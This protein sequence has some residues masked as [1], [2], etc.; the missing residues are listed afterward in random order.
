MMNPTR[1]RWGASTH[2]VDG[3]P[4][5]APLDYEVGFRDEDGVFRP[6]MIVVGELQTDGLYAAPIADFALAEGDYV[7]A[8]RAIRRDR[9]ELVS[10]WSDSVPFSVAMVPARPTG[11]A[12]E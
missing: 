7:I 9:P 5:T 10:T 4:V 6:Y 2:N 12:V 8:M 1:L 3:S 11:L